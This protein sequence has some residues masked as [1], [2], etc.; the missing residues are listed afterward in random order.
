MT[1]V[2]RAK[3]SPSNP[4]RQSLF[5]VADVGANKAAAAASA[6]HR[7]QPPASPDDI[8]GIDLAIPMP[9]HSASFSEEAVLQLDSLVRSHDAVFM[10]GDTRE[11][12]WLPSLL[13]SLHARI[14]ITV[15][16]GFDS[17]VA[18]QTANNV[19]YFPENKRPS[20]FF[21]HDVVG[22]R[23]S[24]SGRSLDQQC[25]VT[26][27]GISMMAAGAAVELFA[28]LLQLPQQEDAAF[29]EGVWEGSLGAIPHQ[30]RYSLG[31][32][33]GVCLE[34][35]AHDACPACGPAVLQ[36]ARQD[37]CKLVHDACTDPQALERISG[38]AE[39]AAKAAT[40]TIEG[41]DEDAQ[42]GDDFAEIAA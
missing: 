14:G 2:D 5:T 9:G 40:L 30:V 21:C 42:S 10:L 33:E 36:A 25:T 6:L 24:W 15:A 32:F 22:P 4:V 20:C 29:G 28:S 1:L 37:L 16:L 23:D 13:A 34:G 41:V 38:L 7:I 35:Q 19:S 11:S 26:R 8:T 31:K 12:R 17:F 18:M 3:V 27:P 39:L